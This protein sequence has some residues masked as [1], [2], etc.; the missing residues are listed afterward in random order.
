MRRACLPLQVRLPP[1]DSAGLQATA[2]F[3]RSRRPPL[4]DHAKPFPLFAPFLFSSRACFSLLQNLYS[5][6]TFEA[7]SVSFHSGICSRLKKLLR[8]PRTLPHGAPPCPLAVHSPPTAQRVV[9]F[10]RAV[11]SA[12]CASPVDLHPSFFLSSSHPFVPLSAATPYLRRWPHLSYSPAQTSA[13]TRVSTARVLT[14]QEGLPSLFPSRGSASGR[15]IFPPPPF[16]HHPLKTFAPQSPFSASSNSLRRKNFSTT[17]RA[18]FHAGNS[19]FAVASVLSQTL[20]P[21]PRAQRYIPSVKSDRLPPPQPYGHIRNERFLIG[22]PLSDSPFRVI[23]PKKMSRRA[24]WPTV[25][26]PQKKGLSKLFPI[27]PSSC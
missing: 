17:A 25:L 2:T 20:A 13:Q 14:Q 5:E 7:N 21:I 10:R 1:S 24:S 15:S 4:S 16:L 18:P 8:T 22:D 19:P 12:P 3:S 27:T 23:P 6:M 9:V 11:T 26:L